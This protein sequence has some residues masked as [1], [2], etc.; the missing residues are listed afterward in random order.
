MYTSG[1]P[2]LLYISGTPLRRP[3]SLTPA[4]VPV[5]SRV[6]RVPSH[7]LGH[8]IVRTPAEGRSVVRDRQ[9]REMVE[10]FFE[11]I[12]RINAQGSPMRFQVASTAL[13]FLIYGMIVRRVLQSRP[14]SRCVVFAPRIADARRICCE[15]RLLQL[16]THLIGDGSS[17]SDPSAAVVVCVSASARHLA[18]QH[19]AVKLVHSAE[20]WRHGLVR[21]LINSHVKASMSAEFSLHFQSNEADCA[22]PLAEAVRD[23]RVRSLEPY[24]LLA[25]R[26]P[27]L[28][29]QLLKTLSAIQVPRRNQ[30]H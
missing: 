14:N 24:V 15:L 12:S 23:G 18:G 3:C 22:Y 20:F 5:R 19:F 11:D 1:P 27:C 28:G 9:A 10:N 4:L 26:T 6:Q 25:D 8:S 2:Q 17:R 30:I 29:T 7:E 21:N 13:T 16:Q